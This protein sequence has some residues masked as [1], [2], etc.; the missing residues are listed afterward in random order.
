M[1][2]A[3]DQL[4]ALVHGTVDRGKWTGET[5]CRWQGAALTTCV[6]LC[7]LFVARILPVVGP[8]VGLGLPGQ[9]HQV[10]RLEPVPRHYFAHGGCQ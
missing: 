4:E 5:H 8:A 6:V 3:A 10:V 2:A 1:V 9:R 7:G